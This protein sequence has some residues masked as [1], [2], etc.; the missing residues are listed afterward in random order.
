[1]AFIS[2]D[3]ENAQRNSADQ[4]IRSEIYRSRL[5]RALINGWDPRVLTDFLVLDDA[6][7]K[8]LLT[9]FGTEEWKVELAVR[10]TA[11]ANVLDSVFKKVDVRV[12]DQVKKLQEVLLNPRSHNVTASA[13]LEEV[14]GK[15]KT[16]RY[17]TRDRL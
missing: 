15:P 14:Y 16:R 17:S 9:S 2:R 3:T 11:F 5:R 6:V 12:H 8:L 13:V 10:K 7:L 4:L 1:M